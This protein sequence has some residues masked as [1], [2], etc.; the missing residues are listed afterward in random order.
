[1]PKLL[2][3]RLAKES[4]SL[5]DAEEGCLGGIVQDG[6]NEAIRDSGRPALAG[7]PGVEISTFRGLLVDYCRE[8]GARVVFR[9]LRAVSD[10]EYEFQMALM[11][12][13]LSKGVETVFL[14]PGEDCTFLS[15]RLVK[16]VAILGGNVDALVPPGVAAALRQAVG[17][18]G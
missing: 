8:Q 7:I 2:V 18:Q 4:E 1:M 11:N 12:R 16:E 5:L 6:N 3:N 15:S 14:A 10:F 17:R 9:G 13:H